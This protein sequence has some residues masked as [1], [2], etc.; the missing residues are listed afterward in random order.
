M[1]AKKTQQR[2]DQIKQIL[3][4][5]LLV[6]LFDMVNGALVLKEEPASTLAM[7]I[8]IDFEKQDEQTKSKKTTK[9]NK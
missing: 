3:R 5:P 7:A 9:R 1:L 4:G 6:R 2:Y 8:V